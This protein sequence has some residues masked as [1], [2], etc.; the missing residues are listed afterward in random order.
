MRSEKVKV[1]GRDGCLFVISAPSG[2]G[3]TTLVNAVTRGDSSIRVSVSH[4]TRPPRPGESGGVSYHF[5]SGEEFKLMAEAGSFLEHARVFD[6]DYGTS[7]QWVE[8]ELAS[9][10][11][12]ILE[13]DWQG[14]R[15]VRK[16]MTD[17]VSIFILPPDLEM[18]EQRLRAR[19]DD[20]DAIGNRMDHARAEMSHYAEYD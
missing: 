6:H 11:D 16:L 10:R 2:A 13:I 15:Q 20:D 12:V 3:K 1:E 18:L 14:A 9:G 7:R 19:G 5:V 8:G 4:T 17:V